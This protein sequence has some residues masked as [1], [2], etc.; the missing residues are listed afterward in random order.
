MNAADIQISWNAIGEEEWLTSLPN[1]T[2][3]S[4]DVNSID[5]TYLTAVFGCVPPGH[6]QPPRIVIDRLIS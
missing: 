2:N 6:R 4:Y 5:K 3:S 1:E